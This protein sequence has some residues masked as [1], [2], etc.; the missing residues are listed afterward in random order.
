MTTFPVWS[1]ARQ[2]TDPDLSSLKHHA[3]VEGSRSQGD[4]RERHS[5]PTCHFMFD[6]DVLQIAI[7]RLCNFDTLFS[8]FFG[9]VHCAVRFENRQNF[10]CMQGFPCF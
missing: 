9:A 6:E 8:F 4:E 2:E 5:P 1:E 3:N 7:M 10:A